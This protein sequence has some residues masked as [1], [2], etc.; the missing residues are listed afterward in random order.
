MATDGKQKNPQ[1][2]RRQFLR[3]G[4]GGVLGAIVAGAAAAQGGCQSARAPASQAAP[5]SPSAKAEPGPTP[6]RATVV[7]VRRPDVLGIES[8]RHREDMVRDML[9][10][11]IMRLTGHGGAAEAWPLS[12]APTIRSPSSRT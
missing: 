7:L 10:E 2:T 9:D 4:A 11:A 3:R 1:I 6:G 8:L 5:A 12:R